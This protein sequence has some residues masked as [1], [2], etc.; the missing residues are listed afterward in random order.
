MYGQSASWGVSNWR[1]WNG[2]ASHTGGKVKVNPCSLAATLDRSV[3]VLAALLAPSCLLSGFRR[4]EQDASSA[5]GAAFKESE[6]LGAK[7][8]VL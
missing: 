2:A 8:G 6:G 4:S 7:P 1:S 5:Q 3:L